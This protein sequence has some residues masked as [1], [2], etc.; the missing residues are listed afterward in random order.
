MIIHG[1]SIFFNLIFLITP[2][3]IP[4]KYITNS[5]EE[6]GYQESTSGYGSSGYESNRNQM[7]QVL[8]IFLTFC[9]GAK[10]CK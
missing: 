8:S 3:V 5:I 10:I 6:L 7:K 2:L 9:N 4:C 1:I